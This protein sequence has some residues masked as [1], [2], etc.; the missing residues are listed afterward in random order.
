MVKDELIKYSFIT[1]FGFAT[2]LSFYMGIGARK[3]KLP[4]IIGYMILGII[5]G[6]SLFDL[7]TEEEIK[8]VGF[9]NEIILGMVAFSIGAELNIRALKRLGMGIVSIIFSESFLAFFVVTVGVYLLKRD[10]PMALIFGAMAPAS[11]PAGTVAVIQEYRARGSL[12]QA[13]Y[14]VVGFD[15]GLAIIIFGF[16]FAFAKSLLF[17]EATGGKSDLLMSFLIPFKEI[18]ISVIIGSVFGF[19]FCQI[20]RFLKSPRDFIIMVFGFVLMATGISILLH[21]SLILTNMI[22]GFFLVNTRKEV[23]VR[24]VMTPLT[25]IMPLLFIWFFFLAGVHLDLKKLAMLGTIGVIYIITRSSGL[26]MGA[27]IGGVI[28]KVED[29]IK[30]LI[31]LGI[32]SQAGVAIGLSLIVQQELIEINSDHA[33]MI[34]K[35]VIVIV[36]AT[37][38]VFEIIGPIMT[39]YALK[40]AGEIASK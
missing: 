28:G 19:T 33:Q 32:L 20:V 6:P 31:G 12:T 11:A 27:Y 21:Y 9:M 13:L 22:I 10:L 15:D 2:V 7:F 40:K 23:I 26:I 39:R 38:V 25:E 1:L 4:S 34:G 16:A 35:S 8:N 36:T 37:S 30:K 18:F 24:N 17:A 3:L 29:K 5:L 14:A